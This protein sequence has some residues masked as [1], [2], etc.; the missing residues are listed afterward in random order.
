VIRSD[1]MIYL[2]G[3]RHVLAISRVRSWAGHRTIRQTF[4]YRSHADEWPAAVA[5]YVRITR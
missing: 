2:N 3:R 1:R 4:A 5:A